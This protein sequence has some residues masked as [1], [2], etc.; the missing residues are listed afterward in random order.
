[1]FASSPAFCGGDPETC[2]IDVVGDWLTNLQ[3]EGTED[4]EEAARRAEP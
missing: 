4:F 3:N 2:D 1:M